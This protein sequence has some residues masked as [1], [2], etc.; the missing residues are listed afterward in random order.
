MAYT[1]DDFLKAANNAGIMGEFSQY[2]LD[3]AQKYPEFG[4]SVLSLKQDFKK[5]TTAEQ[6]T[7]INQA[8]NELRKSYGNYSGGADGSKYYAG[9]I[10]K[11]TTGSFAYPS[12]PTYE[13]RYADQQ[14][15]LLDELLNR[16]EF[17]WSKEEDPLWGSVKKSYLREGERATADT[18]AKASA[19]T[20]GRPSSY[21]VNAAGQAGDYYA[22]KLNDM[23]PT[24]NQQAYDRYQNEHSMKL[25]ELGALNSQEQ[26]DY[27]KYLD[28]LG[29]YNADRNFQYGAY[30]DTIG[31]QQRAEETEY[32][33]NLYLQE[34]DRTQKS[35][36]QSLAQAQVD[37]ILAAG[38]TPG[39]E[40]LAQ[41][42]YSGEYA[43]ALVQAYKNSQAENEYNK[44]LKRQSLAQA[45]VDAILAAGGT[46]SAELAAA[47]G[48]SNEYIQALALA[49]RKKASQDPGQEAVSTYQEMYDAGIRSEGD[50][51]EYALR[52]GRSATEAAKLA[53]YFKTWMEGRPEE[54]MLNEPKPVQPAGSGEKTVSM[55]DLR[56]SI[57]GML[58]T[59]ASMD[60]LA[61]VIDQFWPYLTEN[62]KA[63]V[64]QILK[65]NGK[66]YEP[67]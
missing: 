41:A 39:A 4:L 20:G 5:A 32:N 1:Y 8:A 59:G 21:A 55:S 44:S 26:L 46:P 16:K 37:A 15:K 60:Q 56:R 64:Q 6:K 25:Q 65:A 29:Q 10:N 45:Q 27:A 53:G 38:G 13:N 9:G 33:R 31:D 36:Q 11:D 18:L 7:L 49:Y 3:L 34:L 14:Q 28:L 57:S 48:Y 30:R 54:V 2:D 19:A 62:Q 58:Q 66:S 47:S 50:A 63:D 42:G 61:A 35:Q 43:A 24:L 22:A 52:V 51:Y 23:I 40:L 17:S 67:G 12:A